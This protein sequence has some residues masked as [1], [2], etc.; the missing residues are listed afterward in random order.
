LTHTTSILAEG[1][2]FPEGPR[3]HEGKLW[4]SD[5][6]LRKVSTL[7]LDGKLTTVFELDDQPSGAADRIRYRC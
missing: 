1:L 5:F 4:F 2:G 3:W 7:G 6:R